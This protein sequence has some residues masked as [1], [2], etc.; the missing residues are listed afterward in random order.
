MTRR[1]L[2]SLGVVPVGLFA[3]S[4]ALL[5]L[6][7]ELQRGSEHRQADYAALQ[8][9]G[10]SSPNSSPAHPS[11]RSAQ[12]LS[13]LVLA[14]AE[15]TALTVSVAQTLASLLCVVA[16]FHVVSFTRLARRGWPSAGAARVQ[17]WPSA[18][19]EVELGAHR[20]PHAERSVGS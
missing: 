6:S 19:R 2:I 17:A 10:T 20:V 18:P 12:T 1:D 8:R 3:I 16:L 9:A 7:M 11:V 5:W 14:D 15:S 4:I 13:S